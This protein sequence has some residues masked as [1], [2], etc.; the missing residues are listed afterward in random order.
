MDSQRSNSIV[1][2]AREGRK[3]HKQNKKGM[4]QKQLAEL[5]GVPLRRLRRIES[6]AQAATFEDVVKLARALGRDPLDMIRQGTNPVRRPPAH[7]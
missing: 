7:Q 3:K 6:G 5:S 2:K 1:G 4:T